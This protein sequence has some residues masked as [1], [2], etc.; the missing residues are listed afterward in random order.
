MQYLLEE[1]G[2]GVDTVSGGMSLYTLTHSLYTRALLQ[3]DGRGMTPKMLAALHS[4]RETA[5]VLMRAGCNTNILSNK[6]STALF[7]ALQSGDAVIA[8]LL[9]ETTTAG[10]SRGQEIET[11]VRLTPTVVCRIGEMFWYA[12]GVQ[13]EDYSELGKL[14]S[15]VSIEKIE[16]SF[17]GWP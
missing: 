1:A 14:H 10:E 15:E 7:C 17:A 11:G 8:E 16:Y 9:A 13:H 12:S 6:G 5:M 2:V 4:G 3:L